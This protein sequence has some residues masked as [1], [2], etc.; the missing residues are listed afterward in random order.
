MEGIMRI[1]LPD[2]LLG[3]LRLIYGDHAERMMAE[4]QAYADPFQVKKPIANREDWYKNMR[5]YSV[6]P[7]GVKY[8]PSLS[9]IRNLQ[10]HVPLVRDIHCNAMHILP[11]LKSPMVDK[12]FDITDFFEI[13]ED[14]GTQSDL[15]AFKRATEIENIHVFMD[16]V[17][18]HVSNEHEWFKKA[19]A[20][21]E[22][23]RQ[24]F[25]HS[26][27]DPKI[28]QVIDK[29]TGVVAEYRVDGH[30]VEVGIP[31]PELAGVYP[32]WEQGTDGYWYYHTF[33]P[34]EMDLNW[35]NPEVFL[36]FGKIIMYWS[37][38]GFNYRLDAIPFVGKGAYKILNNNTVTYQ[39]IAAIRCICNAVHP[40]SAIL[41][42]TYEE[43]GTI[44]EYFETGPKES[45]QLAYNFHLCTQTWASLVMGDVRYIW[46]I[47]DE[48]GRIPFMAQWLNFLRNHDE[49]SLDYL[50]RE[51]STKVYSE[52]SRFG[53][54]FREGHGVSGRVFSLLGGDLNRFFM[55]FAL[56]ASFPN[57]LLLYYGDEIAYANVDM[58]RLSPAERLD[59]RNVGRGAISADDY[60]TS[61][62]VASKTVISGIF[63]KKDDLAEFF[64][65]WPNRIQ[66]E[67]GVFS[68]FYENEK[69]QK[70]FIYVNVSNLVQAIAL[71]HPHCQPV[72][73]I[74]EANLTMPGPVSSL[75][76]GPYGAIWLKQNVG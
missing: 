31:F 46:G 37:S 45:V 33:Y 5:L 49:L 48:A 56:L 21:D 54:A 1:V 29:E 76:L 13:R 8:D 14:L 73:A 20:G 11:F 35:F 58:E 74:N 3:Y 7:D 19:Q 38:L 23:Y 43:L 2:E 61:R 68:V 30:D 40:F 17:L 72:L 66:G 63:K 24:Y 60:Q 15:V 50:N 6:Y 51:L 55:A 71:D 59:T 69:K 75:T 44:L 62:A 22:R 32:H 10:L 25:I 27:E 9:P 12:G 57:S 28:K 70:L 4:L 53:L 41:V 42:E 26:R 34:Q 67:P 65:Q 18:N 47:L 39:I 36:E 64:T 52:L 16:M